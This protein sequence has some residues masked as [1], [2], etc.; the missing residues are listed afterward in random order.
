M[1]YYDVCILCGEDKTNSRFGLICE[2]CAK[3]LSETK[4]EEK[5]NSGLLEE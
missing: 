3:L 5:V 1:I 4:S 2:K